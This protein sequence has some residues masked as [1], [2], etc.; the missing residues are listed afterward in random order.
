MAFPTIPS[1]L[2]TELD[3]RFPDKA[4]RSQDGG[5]FAFGERSGEQKV[6]DLLRHEYNKQQEATNVQHP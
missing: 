5:L 1:G 4:P 6:I 3:K 2:L